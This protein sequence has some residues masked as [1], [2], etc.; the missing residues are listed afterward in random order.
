[1]A[2]VIARIAL[3]YLAASLV[4][5]GYLD[6]DL[7]NQIGADPDLIMLVGLALGAGVEMAYAAAKRLGWAT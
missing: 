3:R 2:A 7:G 4:T 1:M 5:A 6:A